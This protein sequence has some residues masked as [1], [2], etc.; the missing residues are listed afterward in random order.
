M[1]YITNI[2]TKNAMYLEA[3]SWC[4]LRKKYSL[5]FMSTMKQSNKKVM[6]KRR[7]LI[8]CP[9]PKGC[10][11]SQRFRFEQYIPLLEENNID[12]HLQP[13]LTPWGWSM[14]YKKGYSLIK[15]LITLL[16]FWRRFAQLFFLRRYNL[17]LIHREASPIGPPFFEWWITHIA[18]KKIIYDFDDA[19]WINNTANPLI[20][21]IKYPEKTKFICTWASMVFV[22]NQYLADFAN[23]HNKNVIVV[24]TTIDT[25]HY[26]NTIKEHHA[27]KKTTE[28]C[29][30]WT[31]SHSTLPYLQKIEGA[32]KKVQNKHGIRL[33]LIADKP[34]GKLDVNF[35]YV[36]WDK[37]L[38]I[39]QLLDIDIG[40]MPL[41]NEDWAKGKCAFKAL[42]YLSLGIPCVAS[43]VGVNKQVVIEDNTGLLAES[44]DE[45]VVALETLLL[46]SGLRSQLGREGR[47]H[48]I[49]HFSVE[50]QKNMFLSCINRHLL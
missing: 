42:Q 37:N 30:G 48:V 5:K 14:V 17:V 26:H 16:G 36:A 15:M 39:N 23:N 50:S 35:D 24:P 21:Q 11:G 22:G 47:E 25:I 18:K 12:V 38:E 1:R 3:S 7:L 44:E 19:I 6:E 4:P 8:L 32:L 43:P 45:W 31:G 27:N 10:A 29:V 9:Y 46:D 20:Y 28:L 34:P 41:P 49:R 13:F 2:R 33:K 40:I